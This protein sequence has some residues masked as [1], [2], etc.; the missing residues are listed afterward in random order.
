[1]FFDAAF[2]IMNLNDV[3]LERAE[4][5]FD[6]P[7][8]VANKEE[9]E[10]STQPFVHSAFLKNIADSCLLLNNSSI[11]SRKSDPQA[12]R[13]IYMNRELND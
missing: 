1:M 8:Y 12:F 13:E 7:L 6:M 4:Y 10:N 2:Q 3:E 11:A 5:D 9:F